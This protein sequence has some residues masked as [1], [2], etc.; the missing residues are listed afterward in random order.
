M[1]T[2]DDSNFPILNHVPNE[3][4]HKLNPVLTNVQQTELNNEKKSIRIENERYLRSHP[5]IKDIVTHFLQEVL[6]KH[7][8]YLHQYTTAHFA[9]ADLKE[10]IR[11][12]KFENAQ[13]SKIFAEIP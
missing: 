6:L 3:D 9:D 2:V 7:P 11:L 1:S 12:C 13:Y 8:N 10:K 4:N 5:E